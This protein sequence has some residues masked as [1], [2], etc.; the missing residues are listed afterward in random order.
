MLREK[1]QRKHKQR[2]LS[3][4][5]QNQQLNIQEK[6]IKLRNKQRKI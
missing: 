3:Q 4:K 6:F 1:N 2:Q 5:E